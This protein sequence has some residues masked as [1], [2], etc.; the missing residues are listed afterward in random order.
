MRA[1]RHGSPRKD[2]R[3]QNP[4]PRDRLR[5]PLLPGAHCG[6]VKGPSARAHLGGQPRCLNSVH[7]LSH[8][9]THE[10]SSLGKKK[11]SPI[12]PIHHKPARVGH[13]GPPMLHLPTAHKT[14]P[15]YLHLRAGAGRTP[16]AGPQHPD[17]PPSPTLLSTAETDCRQW[18]PSVPRSN[19]GLDSVSRKHQKAW[20]KYTP[21]STSLPGH[22]VPFPRSLLLHC[23]CPSGLGWWQL[24]SLLAWVLHITSPL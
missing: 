23:S 18:Q 7:H 21:P 17:T 2:T 3:K 1:D 10:M 5:V 6:H 13:T 16:V 20:G 9:A 14:K 24:P 22:S 19:L 4:S 11:F 12:P 15:F 8:F